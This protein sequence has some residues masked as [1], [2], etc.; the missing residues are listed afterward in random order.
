ML[1]TH[2]GQ[3]NKGTGA[4]T[5]IPTAKKASG[6]EDPARWRSKQKFRS[7]KKFFDTGARTRPRQIDYWLVQR[8]WK[9]C[10]QS[11]AVKWGMRYKGT[12]GEKHDHGMVVLQFKFTIAPPPPKV[13]KRDP[14]VLKTCELARLEHD[15]AMREVLGIAKLTLGQLRFQEGEMNKKLW[16]EQ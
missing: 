8:R 10:V 16:A 4:A 3:S 5:Y 11:S 6:E 13:V 9:S 15:N 1:E 2:Q 12:A 14:S 7:E